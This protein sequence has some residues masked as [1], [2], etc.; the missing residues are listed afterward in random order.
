MDQEEKR[1]PYTKNHSIPG[2]KSASSENNFAVIMVTFFNSLIL[3]VRQ[4]G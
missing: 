1:W 3:F 4:S 2:P